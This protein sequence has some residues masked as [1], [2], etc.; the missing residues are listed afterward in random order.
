MLDF[1]RHAGAALH[2]ARLTGELRQSTDRVLD[3]REEER[4]RLRHEL[5]DS[6]G[7]ILAGISLGLHAAQR[8]MVNDT[9]QAHQL[10]GHLEG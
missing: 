7:P 1:A 10:V 2:T 9:D 3:A 6:L 4:R 5:H 8:M